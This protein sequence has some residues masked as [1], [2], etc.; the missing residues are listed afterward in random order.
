MRLRKLSLKEFLDLSAEGLFLI[1]ESKI[2][3]I[4]LSAN[5][6]ISEKMHILSR[7]RQLAKL[8]LI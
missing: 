1:S 6:Y 7:P 2:H 4:Y 5:L 8:G 3:L